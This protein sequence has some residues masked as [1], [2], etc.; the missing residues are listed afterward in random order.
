[1]QSVPSPRGAL[2]GLAPQIETWNTVHQWSFCQFLECQVPPHTR[3]VP[4][5]EDFLATVLYAVLASTK[6]S[7]VTWRHTAWT[8]SH[9]SI[10]GAVQHKQWEWTW[11]I[12]YRLCCRSLPS[13]AFRV[14]VSTKQTLHSLHNKSSNVFEYTTYSS[15]MLCT[16]ECN[17]SENQERVR[18][19][20][21]NE[22]G[23]TTQ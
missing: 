13:P 9:L 10:K 4:P 1:M 15:E 11:S 5:I 22:S 2:V 21:T 19:T 7:S 18:T 8:G 12:S 6:M 3:K 14:R 20:W 16:N 17:L 23:Q